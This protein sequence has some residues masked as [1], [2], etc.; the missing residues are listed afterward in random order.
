MNK[1][2]ENTIS[3]LRKKIK[4]YDYN[5]YVLANSRVSDFEYDTRLKELEALEQT[6]PQFITSDSPT[7]RV[8]SDLTKDFPSV[9]H[10]IPM[11]S[12]ANSYNE[13][14]LLDF[15]KRI[16]NLLDTNDDIE[17]VCELKIDGVSISLIYE[18]NKF[19]RAITRGD[20]TAGEDVTNNIKTIRSIPLSVDFALSKENSFFEVRGEV[21]MD[22]GKFN[23]LNEEREKQGL[24]LFANP[25]NSTAGTLKLQDPK[26]VNE[27]PL[28]A[29]IYYYYSTNTNFETQNESLLHISDLGLKVNNN[30]KLCKN[31][32][33]V[34]EY[35][36]NWSEQRSHLDYEIDGVVIK[37]NQI[38]FQNEL[39]NV[40]K[41]PRWAIAYK[42]RAEQI[43]T[44]L[45]KITW[46]IGRTGAV[47]PVAELT[48]VFLAGSTIS[49]ATLHNKDE[50]KRKDIREGD[51]V[52]IEKGG[53]VIPKVVSVEL[54]NREPNSKAVI[55]PTDCPACGKTLFAP[56]DEVAIYCTNNY[57]VAQIKGKLEHFSSRGAMDIEG[58][59]ESLV[60]LFVEEG[61]LKSVVDIYNLKEKREDL[62]TIE[63]L[64]EKSVD[65]L[66]EAIE[67]SK[68]QPFE[69]LLFAIGIR[70]VGAGVA[71]KI[72]CHFENIENLKFA[73]Q[74]EIESVHEIGK[75]IATSLINYFSEDE[76]I[77]MINNLIK[78]GLKFEIEKNDNV[79]NTLAD[80]IFIL[81]GTLIKYSRNEAKAEIEKRGGRVTS[82]VSKK[83]S[84]V[85]AGEN[86]GSKI[87]KAENLAIQIID[88]NEFEK[89][90]G[91]I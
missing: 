24:K 9:K 26:V 49:R 37:V 15:D 66:L 62:I 43:T 13:D 79:N 75:S 40:A 90:L 7:Q 65:N 72:V 18:N 34:L 38:K 77:E 86:P 84:Y 68:Q 54:E 23:D 28:D 8:G 5:Y 47:T 29:F 30:F 17:Y 48:P 21:F 91:A 67:K 85:L 6:Y 10:S 70:F 81:T 52:V 56:E 88:E 2:V 27:R 46:Q 14:D 42:F 63:R 71:K 11:L 50:I 4:E 87:K 57:C 16:K 55:I 12:L 83:T 19:L 60:D 82:S 80:K 61:L 31:I 76:N 39:G 33:E 3:D 25:R 74:E 45:N 20:G 58:L 41:S 73:S 59:G 78:A 69:K 36:S 35:C 22:K 32:N 44:K 53:D 89:L 51:V 64:G 1:N